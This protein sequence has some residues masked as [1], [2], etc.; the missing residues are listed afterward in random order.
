MS[1]TYKDLLDFVLTLTSEQLLQ[2]VTIQLQ[3]FKSTEFVPAD[4]VFLFDPDSDDGDVL[5]PGHPVIYLN[6]DDKE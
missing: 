2:N 5:D 3:Q 4:S 1:M 6:L